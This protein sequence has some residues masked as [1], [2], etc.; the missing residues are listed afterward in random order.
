MVILVNDCSFSTALL[1]KVNN[2]LFLSIDG[3]CDLFLKLSFSVLCV[4][5]LERHLAIIL[6]Y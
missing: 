6:P 2:I 5:E 4:A 1:F 3:K